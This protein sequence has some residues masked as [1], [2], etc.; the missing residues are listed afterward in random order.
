[1][2]IFNPVI[3]MMNKL[4]YAQKFSLIGIIFVAVIISISVMLV[5][6]M[7]EEIEQMEQRIE[8]AAYNLVLKDVLKYAQQH[9]GTSVTAYGGD[10]EAQENLSGIREEMNV[11]LIKLQQMSDSLQ[12]EIG[13]AKEVK[14]I[15]EQ[16]AAIESMQ[17]W[18]NT[19][20][21]VNVHTA[22]TEHIIH[23]MLKV[24]NTSKLQLARTPESQNLITT[25]TKT[26]PTLT[27]N[28]GI[29]RASGMAILNA[30]TVTQAQRDQIASK[31]YVIDHQFKTIQEDLE[32]AFEDA[33]I[34]Q[35]LTTI[36]EESVT[37]NTHYM[38]YI[39]TLINGDLSTM[40]STQFFD[41][42]TNAINTE[43]ELYDAAFTYLTALMSKQ[44]EE[45]QLNRT[46]L[47]LVECALL[48]LVTYLFI[49][50]YLGIKRSVTALETAATTIANG[51]LTETV[52]L[53]TNDEMKQIEQAFNGMTASLHTLV[54]EISTSAQ[55]V[56]AS[57]E[58]LHAGVEETTNSIMHVTEMMNDMADGAKEQTSGL[59]ESE[60]ALTTMTDDVTEI[61]HNSQHVSQLA[62]TTTSLATDGNDV[63]QQS[64]AQM[65][66]IQE[67]VSKTRD[68]IETLHARSE[69]ITHMLN[70][71]TNVAEQTNLLS[72]N[73]SIEAAR[74]GEHGKGFAVVANE[75]GKLAAQARGAAQEVSTLVEAIQHDTKSSVVMMGVVT[76]KVEDGLSLSTTT[77]EKFAHILASMQQ[78]A[79]QMTSITTNSTQVATSTD[80]VVTAMDRM[81]TIS[82]RNVNA[83][84]EVAS[85]TEEQT[86]SMEEISASATELAKMAETLQ[87]LIHSFKV[88]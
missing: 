25:L 59:T 20:Q 86:A 83:A 40:D 81:K 60:R 54:K 1:M 42:A 76:E 73:A 12:Y 56:A 4:K 48:L 13:I 23:T 57:S 47:I 66:T 41:T 37:Q 78:L 10:A 7:N 28:L 24:S 53:H 84:Q 67:S 2:R 22:L 72:L 19:T 71:I 43:F 82:H 52:N 74:A 32:R 3:R 36:H 39:E 79:T 21:I 33:E 8:G 75:V 69:Q 61:V 64:A 29:V 16:W 6:R 62:A 85:A 65:E 11:A 31:Y 27:E 63:V 30:E 49:G 15:Q 26:M 77:A 80:E 50:F 68:V 44:M 58:E 70:L 55:Y 45:L 5:S 17:N 87:T 51:D 35:A 9:R 46:L 14:K 18:S 38:M 34:A 88:Q